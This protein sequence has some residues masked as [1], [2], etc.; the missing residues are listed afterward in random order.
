MFRKIYRGLALLIISYFILVIGIYAFQDKIVFQGTGLSSDYTFEFEQSFSEITIYPRAGQEISAIIFSPELSLAKGTLFYFHGNADNMQRW[1]EYAVDFTSLGYTVLMIDYSGF[2][3][4]TGQPS[5][6]N[7]YQ[8]AEDTWQWAVQ[9]LPSKNFIIYGRSLGAAVASELASKH[10][11]QQLILESPFYQL[12]QKRLRIFFPFGL[13][14]EFANYKFLP[15]VECPITIIQGTK[16]WVVTLKSAE[17]LKPF[18]KSEDQFVIID[19][20]GHKNLR[21]FEIYHEKLA[22][23]LR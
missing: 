10:E 19:G 18:L 11:P 2:G 20:G 9:H 8:D 14:Y 16:D 17:K 7:V 15:Q 1:G 13:K 3:K 22:K 23:V 4:S 12:I 5:E 6:E 21:D